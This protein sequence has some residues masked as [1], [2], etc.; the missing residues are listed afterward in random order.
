[1]SQQARRS[2]RQNAF[3]R[4]KFWIAN[5][6][7]IVAGVC[8]LVAGFVVVWCILPRAETPQPVPLRSQV[9]AAPTLSESRFGNVDT[10]VKYLGS[11]SCVGCHAGEAASFRQTPHSRALREVDAEQEPPPGEF[12]HRLSG[13][14]YAVVRHEREMKHRDWLVSAS[15]TRVPL[16]EHAVRYAIGSG[17]QARTYIVE[18]DSFLM[19]SPITWYAARNAWGMSPGFDRP[20]HRGFERGIKRGCLFCHSGLTESIDES[21]QRVA[22]HELSIG[23]ERCHGPGELHVSR[24]QARQ[25]PDR[26]DIDPTIVNPSRL[27][28]EESISVCAQCHMSSAAEAD[29]RGRQMEDFRPGRKLAEYRLHYDARRAS[30]EMTVVGHVEQMRLSR[31][32]TASGTMTCITC[33]DPHFQPDAGDRFEHFRS[34]CLTCHSE[35]SC[36]L[37]RPDR[38]QQAASRRDDCVSCHMPAS[39]TEVPHVASTHHRVGIHGSAPPP[40][41][42]ESR[43]PDALVLVD[44]PGSLSE[45]ERK[46]CL[47]LAHLDYARK[48]RQPAEI[49]FRLALKLLDEVRNEGIG[50]GVLES[51]LAQ[52]NYELG[53][54]DSAVRHGN[55]ALK[56]GK[57]RASYR[58]PVLWILGDVA[59]RNDRPADAVDPL[60]N[61]MRRA[62]NATHGFALG[63]ALFRAGRVDEAAAALQSAATYNPS[64]V[65]IEESLEFLY[66]QLKD[67]RSAE[68]HRKRATELE[69][70]LN[71]PP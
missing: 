22:I 38:I 27:S 45:R 2:R 1:M 10:S 16:S 48:G 43:E 17:R 65:D 33:H 66:E 69:N 58:D 42:R 7:W 5:R 59:L 24:R 9:I 68:L 44:D 57:L 36:R 25:G 6:R 56:D 52:I 23:C 51:A 39:Q 15:G 28:R 49:H 67:P 71:N 12:V 35:S 32:F 54:Y 20:V 14:A 61:L 37:P 46:R 70:A 13:R 11:E 31:C 29:V 4:R 60:R 26:A 19:E 30:E 40:G 63:E 50:D 3:Q 8:A 55:A 47:G 41:R 34:R 62:P 21:E 64:R 53:Q 18:T